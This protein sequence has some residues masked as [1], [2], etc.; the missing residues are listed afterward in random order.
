MRAYVYEEICNRIDEIETNRVKRAAMFLIFSELIQ[1]NPLG[2]NYLASRFAANRTGQVS[3]SG[4]QRLLN[5]LKREDLIKVTAY[6]HRDRGEANVYTLTQEGQR[7]ALSSERLYRT[8]SDFQYRRNAKYKSALIRLSITPTA[9][10]SHYTDWNTILPDSQESIDFLGALAY[11]ESNRYVFRRYDAFQ[12]PKAWDMNYTLR[13]LPEGMFQVKFRPLT[14][15]RLQSVP[16]TYIGKTLSRFITPATDP[17]LDNGILFSLDYSKQELRILSALVPDESELFKWGQ[18][19]DQSF[20]DLLVR[21]D[22]DLP[23]GLQKEYLYAFIYGSDGW[24]LRK[25][26]DWDL[27][28][29]AGFQ[30][31]LELSLAIMNSLK[32]TFPEVGKLRSRF[33]QEYVKREMVTARG[34]IS[35]APDEQTNRTSKGQIHLQ[36]AKSIALS[37]Y[38]QGTAAY[39]TRKVFTRSVDL[40][41]SKLHMPIHDGFVFYCRNNLY[42]EALSEARALLDWAT[43]EVMPEVIIPHEL[44]WTTHSRYNA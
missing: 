3:K 22:I 26:L 31:K 13:N 12:Y 20:N 14:S 24:S 36:T 19:P 18:T 33:A 43:R 37:H 21:A 40:K 30:T 6:G 39:I 38:I 16:H 1:G 41:Y 25:R 8:Y 15:G 5:K 34:G 9:D 7:L 29:L 27:V 44:E 32:D 11:H 23:I 42:Q 17:Y 4:F 2:L 35:R 10:I 28:G